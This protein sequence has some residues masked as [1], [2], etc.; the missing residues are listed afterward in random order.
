MELLKRVF[1]HHV[2]FQQGL[3]GILR[4]S[5]YLGKNTDGFTGVCNIYPL[6]LAL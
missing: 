4:G 5:R 6:T 1:G 3:V 2:D